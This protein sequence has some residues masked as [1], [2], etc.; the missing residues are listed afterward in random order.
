MARHP[1]SVLF[2]LLLFI[3]CPALAQ[4][5]YLDSNGDGVHTAADVLSGVGATQ[6]DIWLRTDHNRDGS[7]SVCSTGDAFTIN[8]YTVALQATSGTVAWSSLTNLMPLFGITLTSAS[9]SSDIW[10]GFAGATILPPGDYHLARITIAVVSGTPSLAIA[11]SVSVPLSY[12]LTSFGSMCGGLDFDNTM[13]LGQDW[14]DVDGLPYSSGGSA[15]VAPVIPE[16]AD[17]SMS[18]G[19]IETRDLSVTDPDA[20]VITG[21]FPSGPGFVHWTELTTISGQLTG[22]IL[23]HPART[24]AGNHQATFRASDGFN[25]A[26]RTFSIQVAEGANHLPQVNPVKRV[27]LPAGTVSR[28]ALTS[29]DADGDGVQYSLLSGPPYASVATAQSG[30]GGSSGYLTLRPTL[31]DIGTA[32]AVVGL[33]DGYASTSMRIPIEVKAPEAPTT[34][35]QSIPVWAS[36]VAVGD[37][38][39]DGHVDAVTVGES[40]QAVTLLQ[41][42]GSGALAPGTTLLPQ[43][44]S[45]AVAVGD[46]NHDGHADIAT[47]SFQTD[48]LLVFYGAGNG[49]FPDPVTIPGVALT[50]W[51]AVGDWNHDGIDDLI[52]T[53]QS[54]HATALLGHAGSGL[55]VAST[56]PMPSF[57]NV[58]AVADFDLDGNLDL[59]MTTPAPGVGCLVFFGRGDGTFGDVRGTS[60]AAGLYSAVAGDWNLDGKADLAA[61]QFSSTGAFVALG[62]GQGDFAFSLLAP[63]QISFQMGAT[64]WNGDGIPDLFVA[65]DTGLL[66]L[67]HGDG[68]FATTN[69]GT[70]LSYGLAFA[71]LDEDG[72]PDLLA[73]NFGSLD[74]LLNPNTSATGTVARAFTSGAK[75]ITVVPSSR[76]MDVYLEPMDGSFGAQDIDPA[77]IRMLS[78]GTGSVSSI[79]AFT[80]KGATIGDTDHDG[81]PDLAAAFRMVDMATLFDALG[82]KTAVSVRVQAA[83]VDGRRLCAPLS[84]TV[85]VSGGGALAA[86]VE[87]NPLNPQGTLRFSVAKAGPVTVRLFDARGRL[88]KTLWDRRAAEPGD[89]EVTIDGRTVSG[90]SMSTGVYFYR[91]ETEDKSTSGR[92]AVLK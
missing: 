17:V 45:I 90:Q 75:M 63:I 9:T 25:T 64:D 36:A 27:T 19:E 54:T 38:N 50:T 7:L 41:G 48:G 73:A 91:I 43:L 58:A 18:V 10:F 13:K 14:Q 67:G 30:H 74:V 70:A 5:M 46:W 2:F 69:L 60:G 92:F 33:S 39:E 82:G 68:T 40:R 76:T 55:G 59:A 78:D 35:P 3:P 29:Y 21:L 28:E 22:R 44:S 89:Q 52:A 4:Y 83:L 62:N 88:V 72:R 85:Y 24:D 79:A 34:S 53:G 15:N 11:P 37:F 56:L 26:E 84:M 47:A 51:L 32:E 42:D 6:A 61:T 86:R 23:V 66:L 57:S 8:S 1:F 71:D 77:S 81:V 49:T 31:C 16:I 12:T 87:P 65:G 20:D 80:G